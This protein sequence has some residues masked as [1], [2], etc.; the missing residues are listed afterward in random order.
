MTTLDKA[1]RK[2]TPE[3]LVIA[4]SRGPIAVAGVMGGADTEVSDVTTN[5]L[6]ES[7]SFDFVSV[8]RTMR[9]MNLPS[10]ASV[11]F[12]KGVPAENVKPAAERALGLMH[13]HGSG[14]VARGLVDRYPAPR[15]D[16]II[17]LDMGEVSATLGMAFPAA[18]AERI[19][20]ALEFHVETVKPGLLRVKVPP[21]PMP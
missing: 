5:I 4:D 7:A 3:N 2:L 8:R 16:Q 6:L 15:P 17:D 12:S 1:E 19:L 10:E 21:H 11:R 20:K 9:G 13:A 14:T 18:E